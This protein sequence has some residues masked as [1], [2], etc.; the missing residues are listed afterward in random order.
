MSCLR[1]FTNVSVMPMSPP[2]DVRPIAAMALSTP[3]SSKTGAGTTSTPRA[4]APASTDRMNTGAKGAVRGLCR[5]ATRASDGESSLSSSSHL[6]PIEPSKLLKPVTL[7]PGRARDWTMPDSTGS[8]K[9]TKTV[10]SD[11]ASFLSATVAGVERLSTRWGREPA[12]EMANWRT[13]SRS[14]PGQRTSIV[15]SRPGA[16]PNAFSSS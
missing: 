6:A 15:T 2:P 5:T 13:R 3:I 7:P 9:R 11:G 12:M 4:C 1:S 10:G 16:Q 14:A 8:A